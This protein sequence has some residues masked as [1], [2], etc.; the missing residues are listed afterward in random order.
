VAAGILDDSLTNRRKDLVNRL[1]TT[2]ALTALGILIVA[3]G[4][5]ASGS[6]SE[7][8]AASQAASQA[9]QASGDAGPS[10]TAGA[11]ADL[12]ALI[13]GTI[14]GFT[15]DKSSSQGDEYLVAPG[16]SPELV[17]FLQDVGVS[18]S[19]VSI[20]IGSGSTADFSSSLFMFVIRAKGADSSRLISAFKTASSTE[21]E[22]TIPWASATVGG[23][24]VETAEASGANTYLYVKGDVLFWITAT[25]QTLAEEVLSGLP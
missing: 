14:G 20:A 21:G 8:G 18:P 12:E 23:K 9:A 22:T 5:A 13:P 1:R 11:V 3:C 7:A 16:S 10:F 17:Q 6:Q 4:P 15:M 24:Q 2:A 19:D 25:P